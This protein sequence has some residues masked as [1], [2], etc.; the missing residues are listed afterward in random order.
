MLTVYKSSDM[1]LFRHL[2]NTFFA[3]FN[4]I[5]KSPLRL[6]LDSK[7]FVDFGNAEK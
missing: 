4:F 6:K 2:S 1:G 7:F 5:D 3:F